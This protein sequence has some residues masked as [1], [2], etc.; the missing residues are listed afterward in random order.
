FRPL[1]RLP[2]G[3]E[4]AILP[5]GI[6][7][8][9]IEERLR[10]SFVRN[11]ES[12][13]AVRIL[14]DARTRKPADLSGGT[15]KVSCP[16]AEDSVPG[17]LISAVGEVAPVLAADPNECSSHLLRR[18][19]GFHLFQLNDG[20]FERRRLVDTIIASRATEQEV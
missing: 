10:A 2:D 12:N 9:V 4:G 7:D 11:R 3:P 20:L 1:E 14:D 13:R 6:R 5:G 19:R 15:G 18:D 8:P 17:C 16:R